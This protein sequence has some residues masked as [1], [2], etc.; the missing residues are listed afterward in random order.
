MPSR[1]RSPILLATIVFVALA[2]AASADA[3][4]R[5]RAKSLRDGTIAVTAKDVVGTPR[6]GIRYGAEVDPFDAL[7]S[8]TIG[9][10]LRNC[11]LAPVGVPERTTPPAGC[12][13]SS[14]PRA[15]CR[16]GRCCAAWW[17]RAPGRSPPSR[18][19]AR[20]CRRRCPATPCAARRRTRRGCSPR[21]P[22]A[23][24]GQTVQCPWRTARSC[25]TARVVL[26]LPCGAPFAGSPE[27][28]KR[29]A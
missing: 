13:R 7:P 25:S 22:S 26:R 8:C 27:R 15:S 4:T 18:P 12:A 9:T 1:S 19:S 17:R 16:S 23:L 14:R 21:R 28:C 10:R 6:W 2:L 24:S 11:A 3:V 20:R 5:C 29:Y